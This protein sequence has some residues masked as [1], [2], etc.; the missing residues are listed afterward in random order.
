M[1]DKK[2][3]IWLS[4]NIK[5]IPL[6]EELR[7]NIPQNKLIFCP[8]HKNQNT[9]AAKIYED[10]NVIWCFYEKRHY[11]AYHLLQKLGKSEEEIEKLIPG[12]LVEVEANTIIFK[13]VPFSV[14]GQK[15]IFN[16]LHGINLVWKSMVGDWKSLQK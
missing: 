13:E 7:I 1:L 11:G 10:T 15:D 16:K 12:N 3:I 2:Q 9:P 5:I 6:L 14:L 8:F 4:Q